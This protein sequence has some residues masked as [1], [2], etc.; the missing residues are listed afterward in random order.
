MRRLVWVLRT[1]SK[2]VFTL[3]GA[4]VGGGE[5]VLKFKNAIFSH[6]LSLSAYTCAT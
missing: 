2:P 6:L 4:Q 3:G 5:V 1:A